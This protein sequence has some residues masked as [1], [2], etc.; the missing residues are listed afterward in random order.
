MNIKEF[1]K[2]KELANKIKATQD[3]IRQLKIKVDDILK[4]SSD[5]LA[6]GNCDNEYQDRKDTNNLWDIILLLEENLKEYIE[7]LNRRGK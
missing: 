2:E 6:I 3:E 7:E 5:E 1:L 4:I